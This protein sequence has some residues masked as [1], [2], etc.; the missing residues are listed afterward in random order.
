MKKWISLVFALTMILGLTA[1]GKT[2]P[3][4]APE[5]AAETAEALQEAP[6][7]DGVITVASV[8][9]LLEAIRP[10]VCIRIEP[11]K[12]NI[13][14]FLDTVDITEWNLTHRCV[15][16]RPC[17]DGPEVVIRRADGLVLQ[18]ATENTAD[19][20]LVTDPRYAAVLFF[21]DCRDV[22]VSFLTM[23]H[24]D[25]GDCAGSVTAFTDC[26]DV[27][28]DH[29]DLYGC[30][31]FAVSAYEGTERLVTTDC[32]L[33]DCMNGPIEVYDCKDYIL[34]DRCTMTGSDFGGSYDYSEDY[35]LFFVN[36]T[37]GQRET[38]YWYW[39]ESDHCSFDNCQ[40]MEPSEYPDYE[41][42]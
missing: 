9:E 41:E 17:Y 5:T 1:C 36:C 14:A 21:D 20:E 6:E 16:I 8:S 33:R 23:G 26:R 29:L 34:F 22:T 7:D 15:E 13:S 31:V 28:L 18:G 37:F 4:P 30:G 12:Y 32:T 24:T 3:A 27:A 10:N 25:T 11:G 38:D 40:F 2:E 19:T 39:N 42:G 35:D